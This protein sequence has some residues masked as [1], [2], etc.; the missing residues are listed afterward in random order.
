M[1]GVRLLPARAPAALLAPVVRTLVALGVTPAA[2]SWAGL[3][4]NAAAGLLVARG[5][6]VAAGLVMLLASALDLFDGAVARATGR[7]TPAG[8][9]LDS[10][11]DRV[12]EAAVLAGV[13]LYALDRE[14]ATLATL[15][16]VAVV[17]S[18]L[19]S[20]VRARVEG[21]GSRLTDGL[22]TRAER[23]VVLGIALVAGLLTPALWLLAALTP[24]TAAQRLWLG[25]RAL[26]SGG[27][28]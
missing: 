19:V 16:F 20:Y 10:T 27:A 7:A 2:L 21:L 22:F 28:P 13:L 4:G 3:A 6:L 5:A 15:S 25:L 23:V 11:L 8:A 26:R 12:S 1:S 9:L 14:D 18:L 24:L 17:G